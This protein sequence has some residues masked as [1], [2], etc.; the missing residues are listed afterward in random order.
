MVVWS[1]S[2]FYEIRKRLTGTAQPLDWEKAR[3]SFSHWICSP[4]KA[5]MQL[6]FAPQPLEN[7]IE[8]TTQWFLANG[9]L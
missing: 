2:T 3:E 7:R 4:E 8:Q 5:Q 1:V 6:G 9:W